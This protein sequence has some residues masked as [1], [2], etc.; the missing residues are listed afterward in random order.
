MSHRP[1]KQVNSP[2]GRAEAEGGDATTS[3]GLSRGR[4]RVRH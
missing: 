4:H 2:F 3:S 1:P